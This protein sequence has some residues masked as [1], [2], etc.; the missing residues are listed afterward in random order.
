MFEGSHLELNLDTSAG[1]V[2]RVE[3]LD[4]SGKQIDG[5]PWTRRTNSMETVYDYR[6]PGAGKKMFPA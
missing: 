3:I 1:G 2:A 6:F 4:A 5:Y